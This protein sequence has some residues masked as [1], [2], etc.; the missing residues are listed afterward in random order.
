M[1]I[2]LQTVAEQAPQ[3]ALG[4]IAEM[5]A[6]TR[7]VGIDFNEEINSGKITLKEMIGTDDGSREFIEKIT[8][9]LYQGREAVPLLYKD[10]YETRSDANFPQTMTAKEFGPVQVV[11]LQKWEGG[12]VKFGTIGE[13]VEKVVS[14]VTYAAGIE[15]DEDIIEYNQTWR[16]SEIGVAFGEAYN[17]LLNHIHF[18]PIISATFATTGGGLAAQKAAQKAGTAQLIAFDTDIPTTLRNALSVLPAGSKLLINSS[19]NF[20]VSDAIASSMYADTSPSIVKK[21]LTVDSLVE[22]DGDEVEVG[23]KTYTYTGVTAGEGYFLVP[24]RFLKEYIKHDLRVDSDDGDLSRL[25]ITQ[26]VGRA[27]RAV[28]CAP[29]SKYGIIKVEFE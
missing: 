12:E 9:D 13:G 24:K 3:M 4:I 21:R 5:K 1:L 16:V 8:Y 17:K 29:G 15:Y 20:R 6:G 11:F 7:T 10:L 2:N 27:R 14:F 28:Y 18:Y 25:I 22:Y 23:G 26:V 19:D